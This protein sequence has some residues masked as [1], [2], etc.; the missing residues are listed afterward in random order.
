MSG[1]PSPLMSPIAN[2]YAAP[3]HARE[4]INPRTVPGGEPPCKDRYG[5]AQ[6]LAWVAARRSDVAERVA[7]RAAIPRLLA[8][9]R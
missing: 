4:I 7:W 5:L 3:P 9:L 6:A 8:A 1:L 2:P